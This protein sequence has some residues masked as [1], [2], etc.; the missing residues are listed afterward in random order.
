MKRVGIRVT[1]AFVVA[2]G[3]T[4]CGSE[5]KNPDASPSVAQ[6]SSPQETADPEL[7]QIVAASGD[8][9]LDAGSAHV[10][11]SMDMTASGQTT[12][13][14]GTGSFDYDTG[15]GQMEMTMESPMF[16]EPV[17]TKMVT[18]FPFMYMNMQDLFGNLGQ[19]FSLPEPW[20]K[21]NLQTMSEELGMDLGG[22][23][24]FTQGDM[25]SYSLYTKGVEDVQKVGREEVR[26]APATRYSAVIDFEKLAAEVPESLKP[27]FDQLIEIMGESHVPMEVWIDG[28]GRLVRQSFAMTMNMPSTGESTMDM[29][30]TFYG[31]GRKVTIK[32]PPKDQVMTF[33]ELLELAPGSTTGS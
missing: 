2:L 4:A 24:Q 21:V 11:M 10:E 31:F 13:S 33:E 15:A 22:L 9:L 23:M 6:T 28:Q 12:H 3:A 8:H 30:M 25:S 27:T 14:E 19:Q 29:D 26:G 16:P 17:T 32:Y 5:I 20:I 18:D 1:L 7:L